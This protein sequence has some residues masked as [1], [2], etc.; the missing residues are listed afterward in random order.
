MALLGVQPSV[1]GSTEPG[2]DA[3]LQIKKYFP[4]TAQFV[5]KPISSSELP[6]VEQ[7]ASQLGDTLT[8]VGYM[9]RYLKG[10]FLTMH[11]KHM[12]ANEMDSCCQD[13]VN[14]NHFTRYPPSVTV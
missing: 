8:S 3:E 9:L 10:K 6:K 1:R 12:K 11:F 13:A 2:K 5:E 14:H 4:A 7:V